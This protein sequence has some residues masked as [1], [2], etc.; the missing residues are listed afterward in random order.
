MLNP[1]YNRIATQQNTTTAL[2]PGSKSRLSAILLIKKLN[3]V[4]SS[5]LGVSESF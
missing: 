3:F 2:D 5:I 4:E 1:G